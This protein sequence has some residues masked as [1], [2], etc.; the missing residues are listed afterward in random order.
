[1]SVPCH[2]AVPLG[3][4]VVPGDSDLE[5]C[6]TQIERLQEVRLCVGNVHRWMPRMEG[7]R[8]GIS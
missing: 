3:I 6:R 7:L 8:E 5:L 1:M 2:A 4:I